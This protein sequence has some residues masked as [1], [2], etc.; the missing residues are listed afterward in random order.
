MCRSA[1][2]MLLRDRYEPFQPVR[3]LDDRGAVEAHEQVRLDHLGGKEL[4]CAAVPSACSCAT[5]TNRSSQS[6]PWMTVELLKHT[7]RSDSIISAARNF[8]VPQSHPPAPA[9]PIRTVPASPNL[10]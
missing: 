1:I 3:T 7:S 4:P 6:E 5:D 2:P 9:R 10:G 8:H